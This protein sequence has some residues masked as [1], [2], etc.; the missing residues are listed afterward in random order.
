M[1]Y[2]DLI[3]DWNKAT[4]AI[5]R[6]EWQSALT[7]LSGIRE[8]N[9]KIYFTMGCVYLV[10]GNLEE[11]LKAF[12]R[13]IAKDERLAIGFFQRGAIHVR[14]EKYE[15]A[16]GDYKHAL[17]NLRGNLVID[18]T[19]LGLR[20]KLHTWEVLYNIASVHCRLGQWEMVEKSLDQADRVKP[21]SRNIKLNAARNLLEKRSVFD[22]IELPEGIVFRPRKHDVEQLSMK[23]F[24]GKPMVISSIIPNDSYGGF[25]PLRPQKPDED[26]MLGLKGYHWVLFNFNPQS[27]SEVEGKAGSVVFVLEHGEDGWSIVIVNG[28]KGLLPTAY[29]EPVVEGKTFEKRQ[30]FGSVAPTPPHHRPVTTAEASPE[31]GRDVGSRNVTSSSVKNLGSSSAGSFVVKVHYE[32]TVA[33][34]VDPDVS[35]ADLLKV[36][37]SKLDH[38]SQE[39]QFSYK[40][41]ESQELVPINGDSDLEKLWGETVDRRLTL[42]GKCRDPLAGR[43]VLYRR[44]ALHDYIAQGPGDLGFDEGDFIDVLSEVNEEWLEGHSG[45]NFGIFPRSFVSQTNTEAGKVDHSKEMTKT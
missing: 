4:L 6:D 39:L 10:L 41:K 21:I 36:L 40:D 12:D 13:T 35:Y 11:A 28:Q 7:I 8:G 16:L 32:Y 27:G 44:V 19:Q 5:E 1:A 33:T 2:R 18:Y 9:S 42:W 22:P 31:P 3:R 25:E 37:K 43:T 15:E 24:L 45:G 34:R 23:D 20:H 38:C 17:N 29:L 30:G 14:L 26:T